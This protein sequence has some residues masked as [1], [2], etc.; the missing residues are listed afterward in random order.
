MKRV[1][2]FGLVL[3]LIFGAYWAGSRRGRERTAEAQS[4]NTR[5]V[6]YYV[7]PM[8]PTH[9]SDKPGKAPCGM[10][11]QAVYAEALMATVSDPGPASLRPGAIKITPEKQQLIGVGLCTAEKKSLACNLRLL[12]KVVTDESRSYR[13]NATIDGWI[14]KTFPVNA[15]SSV[16][17]DETLAQFYSPEVLTAAQSL[18]LALNSA[19]RPK[20]T[21][22]ETASQ[23][24]QVESFDLQRRQ[25][26]D[27]LR[28]LGM[29]E[30]QIQELSRTRKLLETIDIPSPADGII[31]QRNVSEGQRFEKGTELFRLADLSHVWILVDVFER[32][33]GL[34]QPDRPV[35]V[36]LPYQG[37]TFT[38]TVS[39]SL[40]Q[41][42][43]ITRTLKLRLEV[44]NPDLVLKPDM[45]VDVEMPLS[46]AEAVVVPAEAIVDTGRRQTVFV[47]LGNGYFEPRNVQLGSRIGDEVQVLQGLIGGERIAASGTFLLDSESRMKLAAAGGHDASAIDVVCGMTVDRVAARGAKHVSDYQGATYYFCS[48][49]CKKKF[50]I[51]PANRLVQPRLQPLTAA[52]PAR[53]RP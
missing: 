6:L 53:L 4:H 3:G 25:Y 15:G 40:P 11:M 49:V 19:D 24:S 37:Q 20:T 52:E 32:D 34:V 9:T 14:S 44:D 7:D 13:V 21:G 42:D 43:N 48:D 46:L 47:E 30:R 8:N 45:F 33:A 28:N 12:G 18:L 10:E 35:K 17:K 5:K 22:E 39:K 36:E 38:A 1:I 50:E 51:D 41:F 26:R 16:K 27:A 29:G 31:L 2:Y 23:R